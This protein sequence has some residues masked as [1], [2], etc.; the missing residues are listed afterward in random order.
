MDPGIRSS[1]VLYAPS[2]DRSAAQLPV[3]NLPRRLPLAS[4]F[5][6]PSPPRPPGEDQGEGMFR[7]V[8]SHS[9]LLTPCRPP[10]YPIVNR[11]QLGSR[12]LAAVFA[13]T[14][15]A[16]TVYG[17]ENRVRRSP[18]NSAPQR[19]TVAVTPCRIR[20]WKFPGG[21]CRKRA[22][23]PPSRKDFLMNSLFGGYGKDRG[24]AGPPPNAPIRFLPPRP[25]REAS[26]QTS[27]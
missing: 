11:C 22:G 25:Q 23:I 6:P 17:L 7:L 26:A 15:C 27:R 20:S 5:S 12:I 19:R 8:T 10:L 13:A 16:T 21:L 4:S 14:P 2:A 24:P 1:W 18:G 9:S 3:H